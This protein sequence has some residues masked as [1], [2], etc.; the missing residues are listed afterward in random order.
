MATGDIM[1]GCTGTRQ[2][3]GPRVH[4]CPGV[5]WDTSVGAGTGDMVWVWVSL[6]T[7]HGLTPG[8]GWARGYGVLTWRG[9]P[10]APSASPAV[11]QPGSPPTPG[12][13]PPATSLWQGRRQRR[14]TLRALLLSRVQMEQ[15]DRGLSPVLTHTH[16][17]VQEHREPNT[18]HCQ[19][20][21][22][23]F[24]SPGTPRASPG[25]PEDPCGAV[26]QSQHPQGTQSTCP[27]LCISQWEPGLTIS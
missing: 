6:C 14:V 20:L 4:V 10:P 1:P 22:G 23:H 3:R 9:S 2:P 19:G 27:A 26:S 7:Q 13:V 18:L 5:A 16:L 12:A 15:W 17:W 24:V 25:G 8:L 21:S 11:T